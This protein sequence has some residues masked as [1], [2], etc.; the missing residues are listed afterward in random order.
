[1]KALAK[2]QEAEF[3][4]REMRD[5]QGNRVHFGYMVSAFLSACRSVTYYQC[6]E[7]GSEWYDRMKGRVKRGDFKRVG[8]FIEKRDNNTHHD[9]LE[10]VQINHI[11]VPREL[12]GDNPFTVNKDQFGTITGISATADDG[13]LREVNAIITHEN[14]FPGETATVGDL[15]TACSEYLDEL[16][17]IANEAAA[18]YQ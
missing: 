15:L 17:E 4:L 13:T 1:M 6:K 2:L 14:F 10:I 11:N 18:E 5:A 7:Y 8:Y 16:W 9:L 3:F 12:S